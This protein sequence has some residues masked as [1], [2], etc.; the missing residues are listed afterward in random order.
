MS[1]L[2]KLNLIYLW[3]QTLRFFMIK[4]HINFLYMVYKVV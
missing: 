4:C 1:F 3:V 2:I